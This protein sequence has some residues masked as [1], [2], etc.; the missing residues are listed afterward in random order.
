MQ[1]ASATKHIARA[2]NSALM[3]LNTEFGITD[4]NLPSAVETAQQ[5]LTEEESVWEGLSGQLRPSFLKYL[6]ELSTKLDRDSLGLELKKLT[7]NK[8]NITLNGQ[9]HDKDYTALKNLVEV[10]KESKLFN[11]VSAPQATTFDITLTIKNENEEP[12]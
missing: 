11:L 2:K 9:V 7:M 4:R 12:A 8:K 3:L 5:K 10:L 6:L 1:Y